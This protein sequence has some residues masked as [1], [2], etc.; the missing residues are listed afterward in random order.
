MPSH[1]VKSRDLVGDDSRG[2]VGAPRSTSSRGLRRGGTSN[3][4]F[5]LG[6][7]A[8]SFVVAYAVVVAVGS[9]LPKYSAGTVV[10]PEEQEE[11]TEASVFSDAASVSAG[12]WVARVSHLDD[13]NPHLDKAFL[14]TVWVNLKQPIAEGKRVVF[15]A[16]FGGRTPQRPGYAL[17]LSNGPD[18]V[19]PQVYW[20][21]ELG[22]GRWLTFAPV[23]IVPREW[24]LFGLSFQEGR[25]VGLH[26]RPLL[27]SGRVEVLGGYDM[28]GILAPRSKADLLVGSFSPTA[29]KAY[30]GPVGVF[31]GADLFSNVP[32]IL[33]A[34]AG[35]PGTL[36]DLIDRDDV[37]LWASPKVDSGPRK[38]SVTL[39]GSTPP[40][41]SAE[42][43]A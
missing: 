32:K 25:Y 27:E 5:L 19:R 9:L 15:L 31:Q 16:K 17:A 43:P 29:F 39:P 35:S 4:I 23:R 33:S 30:I 22:H 10:V 13:L 11:Q 21:D 41:Q 26:S 24:V 8:L 42:D 12:G 7:F 18:G 3:R 36:P 6:A 1:A 14:V 34:M 20:Q 38:L 37:V 40:K 28:D 2:S